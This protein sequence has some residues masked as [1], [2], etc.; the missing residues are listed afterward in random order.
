[1]RHLPLSRQ[2]DAILTELRTR[3]FESV[4]RSQTICRTNGACAVCT[5]DASVMMLSLRCTGA[6]VL[7]AHNRETLAS[8]VCSAKFAS[9]KPKARRNLL[10]Q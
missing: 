4:F 2:A 3:N 6:I 8:H 7:D 10:A 9:L 5:K 1:M